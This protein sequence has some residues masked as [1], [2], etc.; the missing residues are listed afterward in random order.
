MIIQ[1]QIL[2]AGIIASFL[3]FTFGC[4]T[5]P[6]TARLLSSP[7]TIPPSYEINNVPFYS[8]EEFFCGP[9]TLTEAFNFYGME[10]TPQAIA[11]KLFIPELEGSLQIEMISATRQHGFLAYAEKGNLEQLFSLINDNIPV[12][13]LQNV[14]TSWFPMWHYALV[15]GYDIDKRDVILHSGETERRISELKAFERTWQRGK[16]WLLA[17]VPP[18]KTS[19]HFK[20]FVYT[21]AA[22]DL[23]SVNQQV[24]GVSA[25]VSATKQ[26]PDYWLPYFLLGNHYLDKDLAQS[27]NWYQQGFSYATTQAAYLNNFAYALNK[28]A[29]KNSALKMIN[30]ALVLAPDDK[31]IK[32]T[33][34]EISASVPTQT[35]QLKISD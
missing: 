22:Q 31:S 4:A 25:L 23:L 11:P 35:C 29:C 34:K 30:Q 14:A 19:Q 8:Q 3:L 18:S 20:P 27:V 15:I 6:Q 1:R 17:V 28:S 33:H 13:V 12:I 10:E 9:T 24:A 7:L 21:K 32:E 2:K 16:Y 26:W 5:P